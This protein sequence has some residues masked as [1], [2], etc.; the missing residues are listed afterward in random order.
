MTTHLTYEELNDY[1]DELVDDVARAAM[2][3]HLAAC[4]DCRAALEEIK[5]LHL[6]AQALPREMKVPA[7][8]WENVRAATVDNSLAQRRRVLWGLRY[9]LAAAAIVLLV[10][11]S[12]VTW[13]FT[14]N[15]QQ[16][17]Q[18]PQPPANTQLVAYRAVEAEYT[19]AADDLMALLTQRRATL[20][21]AVVRAVEE[22]LRVM[23]DAIS[24]A[25]AA[26]LSD[27]S[28]QDVAGIL[29]ATQESKLRM[30]RRAVASG[31]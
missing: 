10:A 16:I 28:N 2:H 11:T 14:R 18:Q 22:N 13:Y 29:A 21:T 7:D 6:W 31:T 4:G 27:P 24:K 17:S 9:H 19:R 26:L 20:D 1:A 15:Q 5:D 23:D 3:A 30:L 12:S 25:R 8:V